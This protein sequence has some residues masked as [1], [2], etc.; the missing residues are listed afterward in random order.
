MGVSNLKTVLAGLIMVLAGPSALGAE[1]LSGTVWLSA[2]EN[3][4]FT[5]IGEDRE[6][7]VGGKIHLGARSFDIVKVSRMGVIGGSRF[8]VTEDA[9]KRKFGE[10]VTFSSSFSEQTG[11]GQPWVAARKYVHC[12]VPYNS[13]L[14]VYRVYGEAALE[15]LGPLPYS[16]MNEDIQASDDSTVYCFT[17]GKGAGW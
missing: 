11:V 1:L 17:S 8:G 15:A 3:V 9:E 7:V 12:E 4:A 2:E 14:A 10:F 6:H 13:F 16:A 5:L